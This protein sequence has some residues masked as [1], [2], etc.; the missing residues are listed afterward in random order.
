LKEWQEH[1]DE[2]IAQA[3]TGEISPENKLLLDE[4]LLLDEENRVYYRQLENLYRS[5][6]LSLHLNDV[7]V[8]SAWDKVKQQLEEKGEE[9]EKENENYKGN[10]NENDKGK[11]K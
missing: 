1:I 9:N 8:Q 10:E 7:D 4:W 3:I 2:W 6:V 5:D 11:G